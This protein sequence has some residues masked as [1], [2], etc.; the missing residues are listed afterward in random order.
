MTKTKEVDVHNSPTQVVFASPKERR[1]HLRQKMDS[2]AGAE[3]SDSGQTQTQHGEP[4]A[5]VTGRPPG[6]KKKK[7]VNRAPSPAR[8]KE[9]PGWSLTKIRGGI[10]TPTLSVKPGAIHLGSRVSRRSPVGSLPG[11]DGKAERSGAGKPGGKTSPLLSKT[12]KAAKGAGGRRKASDASIGS[13]DASKD[14]GCATGKLSPTDS[15]S[16]MSDCASEE[17]KLSTDAVSSDAESRSSRGGAADG[18][19]PPREAVLADR[20][21]QHAAAKTPHSSAAERDCRDR[22]C[23]GVEP[24]EESVSPGEERSV[25]SFDSRV[26]AS[27]SLAFSDLTEEFM[28]GMHEEFVREIEE[29]RSEND[30]L[31]DEMEELR[32]EMLEMRDM[33]MEDDVYQL[34]DL[35][36]QLEQANKTCRILQYR[37]RK[38]ERR[39]VRVAQTGQVDGELIRTLEQDVK[40]AKD[41]SIR[42]HSQ[43]DS[44]EKKRSRLDQENEELRVRL[45]DLE[46]AK[47]VLQQEID[48]SSQRKRGAR[49]NN[50]PDK[51][52]CP[53]EDSSDLKCQLHFAKEE[54]ALMCKKL[55]KLVKDGDA[56]KEELAKFRSLYGDVNASLTVEEVAD[57]PHTR[58]AEIRVHLKL[59]EE[60][61]NLL[62]RRI[63]ELEV[64]NRGLRAEMDDMK[65]PQD[66]PQELTGIGGSLGL[67]GAMV[68]GGGASSENVMELQRHLQ[69]VEEEAEL[70]RRSLIE[71]EEQNK[72]LM[73]EINRYKSDLPP[74]TSA[75]SSNS[76]ASLTDGL[77]ND[78]RVHCLQEGAVLISTDAPAHEEE[79]RLAR[80]QIGELGGKVKK[81]QYENR[82]L[83]SNLQRCDLAS[84]HAPSSSFSYSSS[85]L[86]LALET[87]AEAGDSAECLPSPPHRKEPVGG[88]T[89][90]LEIKER[91]KKIED[92]ADATTSL[93]GYLGQKDHDALLAMRDQA[94]LVSTAIQ[95]L[96]SPESNCLSSSPSIYHKVCSNEAAEPCDPEKPQPHSQVCELSD[97]A[98]R[99][100]VGALTSRLQA[101]HGQL[102]AFVEQVDVLGR[103]PAGGRDPRVEGASPLASP[104]ASPLCSGDGQDGPSAAVEQQPDSRDQSAPEGTARIDEDSQSDSDEKPKQDDGQS[105]LGEEEAHDA[106]PVVGDDLQTRLSKAEESALVTRVELEKERQ[107]QRDTTLVLTQ[108]QE[109]HQKALLRRDFQ[110]ESLGLQARLQQKLWSQE[111]TLL[112]QESQHLK[113]ALLLLSLRL[114]CFLK[115]WRLGCSKDAELKDFLEMNNLKDLYLLL[116]EENQTSPAHQ[117]DRRAAADEQPLSTTIKSSAVSS[118][119]ADLKVT[120]RDLSG[121]LRQERQGSQELTQQF[122]KAKASWEV[123]RTELKS[124]ITQLETKSGKAATLSVSD[125]PDPPDLKVALKREREEHQHLLADS[126]AAVMDL[127]KQLQIGERNWGREKRELLE[128]FSQERAQWEQRLE[129]ATAQQGKSK[130]F[131]SGSSADTVVTNGTGSPRTKSTSDLVGP[132]FHRAANQEERIQFSVPELGDLTRKNW[133]YLTNETPEVGYSCKTWD[134]PSGSCSSSV[135]SELHLETVQRSYTAPDRTGIRI[136]YSPPVVRRMEHRRR[137]RE[138]SEPEWAQDRSSS[139]GVSGS[140]AGVAV[141]AGDHEVQQQQHPPSSVRSSYEQWLSSLSKQHRELLES[142]SGCVAGSIPSAASNGGS[143]VDG[144]APTSAFHGLEIGEISANLSDDM[145]EMTNCVRQAIRSSSLERKSS[146]DPGSQAALALSTRSTQTNWQYVS[147]GLQTE[148]L[149]SSRGMGLHSKAWS[150]RPSSATTSSLASARTRQISTSLDKVHSRIDRPC[151]SPKYGSPKLQRRVSSGST[152]RLDGSSSSRDRS[153]WSL[154]QRSLSG[155]GRS[156][157]ARSTTTRDSPVLNGLTDGLSSLFSVVEHTG[158]TESLWR[159]EG[160]ASQG[161]S[162]ARQAAPAGKSTSVPACGSEPACQ[163]YG[164]LVQEFFRTVCSNRGPGGVTLSEERAQR[165]PS[166]TL[167][168]L[169]VSGSFPGVDELKP[170]CVAVG[171]GGFGALAV[172]NDNV[173]KIVNK[174][175]MRQTAGEEMV[176]IMGGGKETQSSTAGSVAEDAPCDCAA[177]SSACLARPSRAAARHSLGQCKHR[178]Q[179][180]PAATEEKGD[181]CNE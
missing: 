79:I 165:D 110:L 80:L 141:A 41:V 114:R 69:F 2:G 164:G 146:K 44:V 40:V 47:Q 160:G 151:C 121:E 25:I 108:H 162:P 118:T 155:G 72:L 85:S 158:S 33:Y 78:S 67:G 3:G 54:T 32:S 27:T 92:K 105:K 14:S 1:L 97:L 82:V 119:L 144:M 77:L 109:E 130:P 104:C 131:G 55:T 116:E 31:K 178:P 42:L 96:T 51:K 167:G 75:L 28:D 150:P 48:K 136:Y 95:L 159:G 36:Q 74:P 94:R 115:Q 106:P 100:L 8:P 76:L 142:R 39:S 161:A 57:S 65:G 24:G 45:Q 20:A 22:L 120:L 5:T 81:L 16:E 112:A 107:A 172:S 124:L 163:R 29:L 68:L 86:R 148:S 87:D 171:I 123:E 43:L 137:S 73:N 98:D 62:S 99:P 12:A 23:L 179:E 125:A 117:G 71:I 64:E 84:Y 157:W 6:E 58:E 103:P 10:G 174:R 19:K 170:E 26:P 46:V 139:L 66:G 133:T 4:S 102:Q 127:T 15:S 181:T 143:S 153:L 53:Q 56:M 63:V 11:K 90:S 111:R 132:E 168:G 83:L 50:K 140:D 176:S 152:S 61:A 169:G 38:A 9:V 138:A 17:N 126:Y 180:S 135:G 173:T 13:D 145:K 30:Y 177:Q 70:L 89:E 21:R 60:E 59:V 93:P 175:F 156:A 52:L 35:R 37:L 18:E 147:I 7:K 91:K 88:E 49:P 149:P 113:Q 129:E 101:L 134:G 128:M 154:Q 34:Q 166:V 122:A